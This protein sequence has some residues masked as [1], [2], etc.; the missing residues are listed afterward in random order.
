MTK[1]DFSSQNRYNTG[2]YKY[3][4]IKN[5]YPN[6]NKDSIIMTVADMDFKTS[7]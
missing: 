1:Y 7:L 4:R 6:A 5:L 2:S 3:D